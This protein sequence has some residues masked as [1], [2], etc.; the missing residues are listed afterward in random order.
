MRAK[1]IV[2]MAASALIASQIGLFSSQKAMAGQTNPSPDKIARYFDTIVFGGRFE[3]NNASKV[4]KKWVKPVIN[5]SIQ[6]RVTKDYASWLSRHLNAITK[7][8][9]KKFNQ[10][11][12]TSP[13]EDIS[14]IFVKRHEMKN[15]K[16]KGIDPSLV[17]NLAAEGGCYFMAFSNAQNIFQRAIIVVN[18]ERPDLHVESCLLEEMVQTLGL[19][20]DSDNLRPSLFSDHD[21]VTQMTYADEMLLR[22][23]YDPRMTVGLNRASANQRAKLIIQELTQSLAKS[24]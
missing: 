10:V 11:K 24:R 8:S 9:G 12:P 15:I 7:V 18:V 3:Q 13:D 14:V 21:H 17:Q 16:G 4:I 6:G 20:Y 1:G 23:L 19:P 2:L 5:L 22:T